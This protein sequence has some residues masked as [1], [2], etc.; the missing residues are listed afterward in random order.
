MQLD[1]EWL[2]S[3]VREPITATLMHGL[4]KRH[5]LVKGD[6]AVISRVPAAACDGCPLM[7][8]RY[9]MLPFGMVQHWARAV[10]MASG[11]AAM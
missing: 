11:A 2:E 10:L 5:L 7:Q 8:A 3:F 1:R 9:Q 6:P 4:T